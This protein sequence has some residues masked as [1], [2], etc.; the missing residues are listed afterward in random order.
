MS[1]GA[2]E[3]LDVLIVGAG[4][5]GIDAAY[6]V[7][8]AFPGRSY[9]LLEARGALGGTWDLFRYPGIRSDSDMYTLGFSWKPWLGKKSIADG[10]DILAYLQEAA[11]ENGIDQHIRYHHKVVRADFSTAEARWTVTVERGGVDG[12]VETVRLTA[13][14][15]FSTSGYY[16]YEEGYTP[17]FEGVEEFTGRVIHPQEWPEDLDYAGKRIV[18]IGSGATAVTLI[19]ALAESGAGHVTMLQ[20]TPSYVISQPGSDP[21]SYKMLT[22]LPTRIAAPLVRARYIATRTWFYEFCQARPELARKILRKGVERQLPDD[23]SFDEHFK[24]PYNPWDQRLCAVPHGDLFKALRRHTVDVV[25]DHIDRFTSN[26]ILLKSGRELEADIIVTATGLNLLAFGGASLA[27]DGRDVALPD[28]MAFKGAMLS[29][30]PNFAFIVGYTNASWTLKADLVCQYVVRVMQHMA[31]TGTSIVVPRRDPSV[32][33]EPFLDFAAGY[34]LRSVDQFPKQGSV[35]P[36]RL[37]MNYFRDLKVF[38]ASADDPALE[39]SSPVR[40]RARA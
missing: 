6:H 33:E 20:R 23:V 39:Y 4:L 7:S 22:R 1:D 26:G 37:R 16:S 3:H 10:P 19:P 12:S 28:T 35:E 24:P 17:D 25:T 38:G 5:S 30:I 36:W 2:T 8:K 15:L 18:V 11:A 31:S 32:A 21:L 40:E 13:D 14:F 29:D 9:A 34:V 27:V